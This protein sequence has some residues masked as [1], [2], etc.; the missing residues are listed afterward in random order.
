MAVGAAWVAARI[1]TQMRRSWHH[2]LFEAMIWLR[3]RDFRNCQSWSEVKIYVEK[4]H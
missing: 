3:I 4:K 1:I 2:M